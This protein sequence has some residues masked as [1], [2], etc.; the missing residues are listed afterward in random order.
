MGQ[1]GLTSLM[2]LIIENNILWNFDDLIDEFA[3]KNSQKC[4]LSKI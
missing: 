2:V 3:S 4:P 1:D